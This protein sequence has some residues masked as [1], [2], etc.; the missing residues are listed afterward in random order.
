[1]AL[2]AGLEPASHRLTAERVAIS[3]TGEQKLAG[4]L[5]LEPRSAES[6]SAALPLCYGPIEALGAKR[7]LPHVR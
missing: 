4:P 3:T 2:Q 1:M 7:P 6:E 5:G